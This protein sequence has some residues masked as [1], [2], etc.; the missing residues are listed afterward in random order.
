MDLYPEDLG[1]K[2]SQEVLRQRGPAFVEEPGVSAPTLGAL[3]SGSLVAT[4]VFWLLQWQIGVVSLLMGGVTGIMWLSRKWEARQKQD[5]KIGPVTDHEIMQLW[6]TIS[7]QDPLVRAYLKLVRAIL[8]VS[9]TPGESAEQEIRGA[10]CSLATAIGSLPPP[11]VVSVGPDRTALRERLDDGVDL[12]PISGHAADDPAALHAEA[13][14]LGQHAVT[15]TDPVIRASLLRRAESLERR[16][17]TA[18]R[19]LMLLRRNQALREEIAEQ[20]GALRT[21]LTAF[22]VG[23]KQSAQDFAGLAASIQRVTVEAN[24]I[25]DARAEIDTLLAEPATPKVLCLRSSD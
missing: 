8:S 3:C 2:I 22:S 7:A 18:A 11:E 10:V 14:R 13:G 15:E 24:A 23:G 19:T 16:A 4:L 17:E 1:E 25:T 9:A 21:S 20:I 6:K 12:S 5:A